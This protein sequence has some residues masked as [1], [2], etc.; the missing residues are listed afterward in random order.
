MRRSYRLHPPRGGN[1]VRR[2]WQQWEAIHESI[3]YKGEREKE[4]QVVVAT[5]AVAAEA[6]V[7]SAEDSH[8]RVSVRGAETGGVSGLDGTVRVIFLPSPER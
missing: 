7:M 8:E 1:K 3:C 2:C 6:V 5:T 4:V